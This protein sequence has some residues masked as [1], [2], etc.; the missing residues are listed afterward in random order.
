MNNYLHGLPFNAGS[1][2]SSDCNCPGQAFDP[3]KFK[4]YSEAD[5]LPTFVLRLPPMGANPDLTYAAE[6]L[7][8]FSCDGDE[9]V[10]NLTMN[11]AGVRLFKGDSSY[12][13]IYD[14]GSIPTMKLDCGKC[15]RIKIMSFWSEPFWITDAA[16]SKI[17]IE[18]SN[19]SNLGDVPYKIE[20]GFIQRIIV[21][22][23]ICSLDA[24]IFESKSTESNGDEKITFQRMTTRKR[25]LIY[26]APAYIQ[27]IIKSIQLHNTFKVLHGEDT[28]TPLED[29]TTIESAQNGC[30]DYDLTITLP[31]RD[32]RYIGG[33]CQTDVDNTI[34]EVDI[35]DDLPD[36]CDIDDD[37]EPTDQVL[38]LKPNQVP[39]P[40]N[41]PIT[42]VGTPPVGNPCPPAGRVLTQNIV[43]TSCSEPFLDENNIAYR[44]KM[45]RTKADGNCGTIEET[46]YLE[47][48][49]VGTVSHTIS[50]VVCT[51]NTTPPPPVGTPPVGTPP[52]GTPPVGTPPVGT[53]PVGST[54]RPRIYEFIMGTTGQGF[55]RDSATGIDV[56][57]QERI[58]AFQYS[59]GWGITSTEIWIQWHEY[60]PTPG[61]YQTAAL[62]KVIDYH[63]QRGLW[64]NLAFI[65]GRK[66]NDGFLQESER[67]K[68]SLGKVYGEGG[69]GFKDEFP[70][71]GCDRTNVLIANCVK[72]IINVF[73]TYSRAGS[74]T[75]AGGHTGELLNHVIDNGNN[76][77]SQLADF[78]DDNLSRFNTWVASRGL[79][80]PG[81]PPMVNGIEWP[82]PNFG[83]PLGVE[84]SRFLHFN[85]RKFYKNIV[86]AVKSVSSIKVLYYWGSV[87]SIQQRAIST[88]NINWIAASGDGLYSSDGDGLY[89]VRN[90]ILANAIQRGTFP[91]K[92]SAVEFD[93]DDTSNWK[94]TYGG[95]PPY[96]QANP[97]YGLVKANMEEL[98]SRGVER[99]YTAMAFSPGEIQAWG[100][101]LQLMHQTWIGKPYNPP[102]VTS[103]NTTSVE[104]TARY[105][106]SQNIDE[107]ID[108][109]TRY[110]KYT[111]NDFWGGV[112]PDSINSMAIT[113]H[114]NSTLS[115]YGGRVLF[116]I[117]K[118]NQ[119]SI[120][121]YTQGSNS[122]D[123]ILPTASLSK[124]IV[125]AVMM[126][127]LESG[128]IGLDNSVGS[129][130]SSWNSGAK[131]SITIRHI[132][133]HKSGIP[134]DFSFNG[135]S[136]VESAVN[137][138]SGVTL[139]F[140]P[141]SQT[142]YATVAYNVLARVAEV[143]TSKQ[144][145][146]IFRE[147]IADLC[148]MSAGA[149]FNPSNDNN[150]NAG[151]E[152]YCS[153]NDYSN[154]ME[155][156]RDNGLFNDVQVL[157]SSSI[158][159]MCIDEGGNRG[160]GVIT[161][162]G[163]NEPTG[164]SSQ[165]C[166][167]WVNRSRQYSAVLF[168]SG[169]N[170]E[171]TIGANNE[172]RNKVRQNIS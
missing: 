147:R 114:L 154:F 37:F 163:G 31:L 7:R 143:V 127:L 169:T 94:S 121:D 51:G 84:F 28:L 150:P 59:W 4:L 120:Y 30:C 134:D 125:G 6:C 72:S 13:I 14:G 34:E 24:E 76:P 162:D 90:K 92:I 153:Q 99:I 80:T 101:S 111:D 42:P 67:V 93:P 108:P 136:T 79:A 98:Y 41:P 32:I 88:A 75:V 149:K 15:F 130:I 1:G 133:A 112:S 17:T 78:S 33:N 86:D 21:D 91:D 126:S 119:G 168:T 87:A 107:G 83:N 12:Y 104:V 73:K 19:D 70:S 157:L 140:T 65:A 8:I 52:V 11:E 9:M 49:N 35:P 43:R 161:N 139:E 23:E 146:V 138:L 129:Y 58:E 164:E 62:Q 100:P 156:I 81:T 39:P 55:K 171:S 132:L 22:G 170:Y 135:A 165:G 16:Q 69:P 152:L 113:S 54:S 20:N 124:P 64:L 10:A 110:I 61:N 18:L 82:H 137:S 3:A 117:K 40:I 27:E 106:N 47:Q 122:R 44:A 172:L 109:Y 105:R 38:C 128:L 85:L 60:E 53:P 56:S 2:K 48:C 29:R 159:M 131:A 68:G 118:K 97:Q 95:I 145:K 123:T 141:G 66:E 160:L 36:S 103:G 50:N 63:N 45:E 148:S 115:S 77:N 57:Q 142:K 25:L 46:I 144:W 96:A 71:Y 74:F 116:D 5:R 89:D 166:Y 158:N 151:S 26:H 167:A 155:M 102:A